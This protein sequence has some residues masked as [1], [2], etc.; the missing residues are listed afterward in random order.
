MLKNELDFVSSHTTKLVILGVERQENAT[1][2]RF[3]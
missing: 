1:V 2:W 3:Q